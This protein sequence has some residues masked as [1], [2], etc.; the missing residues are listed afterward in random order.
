MRSL[1]MTEHVIHADIIQGGRASRLCRIGD[2]A[3]AG[4]VR[5]GRVCLNVRRFA[6]PS[7]RGELRLTLSLGVTGRAPAWYAIPSAANDSQ[8][9]C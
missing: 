3:D 7:L 2:C 1:A 5:Q 4:S 9:A 8:F 6:A